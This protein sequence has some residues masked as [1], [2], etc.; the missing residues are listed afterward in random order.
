MNYAKTTQYLLLILILSATIC[1]AQ[2]PLFTQPGVQPNIFVG[3]D[4][5]IEMVFGKG[6][7]IYYAFSKDRGRSFAPPVMVDSLRGLHL[8]FSR[9]PQIASTPQSVV[10]TA[11]D[12]TGDLYAYTLDRK[13]GQ[14]WPRLR[15]NDVA[16]VAEEGF[17]ALASDRNGKFF[18]TWLDLRDDQ[19]N[20]LFGATF[21]DGG[22]GWSRNQLVY[23]SP[24]ST[25]CE[26]CQ[27]SATMQDDKVYVMFRNWLDGARNMYVATSLDGGQT[28]QP[29]MKMGK[30]SWKI[31]AC[32]MD[33]GGMSASS[34]GLTTVWRREKELYLSRPGEA[35]KLLASGR[36][37]SVA[38]SG[39]NTFVV[40]QDQSGVWFRPPGGREPKNLGSGRFPRVVALTDGQAFCVWEDGESIKGMVLDNADK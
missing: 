25:V 38:T 14:W 35:E 39:G 2:P 9:G 8:G 3:A 33:G 31:N 15:V 26:C 12:K 29:P 19:K 13:S 23:R 11:I 32:P 34:D 17:N 21:T 22:Q 36:N 30:G 16:G 10:I 27:P 6:N 20:K 7:A 28:F 37:A 40:W 18:V 1:R 5:N 24:D 4:G